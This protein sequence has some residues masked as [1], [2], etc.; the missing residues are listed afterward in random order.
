MSEYLGIVG[1]PLET[2]IAVSAVHEN[3]FTPR[4]PGGTGGGCRGETLKLLGFELEITD[5][6]KREMNTLYSNINAIS[7][8]TFSSLVSTSFSSHTQ[9]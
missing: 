5:F 9:L 7:I 4:S 1:L 6:S 8:L 3:F 2:L